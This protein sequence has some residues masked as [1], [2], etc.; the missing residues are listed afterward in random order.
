ML[1][2]L[3]NGASLKTNVEKCQYIQEKVEQ[4]GYQINSIQEYKRPHNLKT[5]MGF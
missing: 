1:S 5:L 4:F 3:L 2:K